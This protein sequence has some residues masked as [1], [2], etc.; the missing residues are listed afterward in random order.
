VLPLLTNGD[1]RAQIGENIDQRAA[2][3]PAKDVS[4]WRL[5]R[6]VRFKGVDNPTVRQLLHA[7]IDRWEWD[8]VNE[9]IQAQAQAQTQTLISFDLATAET[10][11]TGQRLPQSIR[12]VYDTSAQPATVFQLTRH[13]AVTVNGT[14]YATLQGRYGADTYFHL[15]LP[16]GT[17][18]G[19]EQ[20]R[21]FLRDSLEG[22]T[23]VVVTPTTCKP[24]AGGPALERSPGAGGSRNSW[25]GWARALLAG[26]G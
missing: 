14:R 17:P 24:P 10:V 26:T 7:L 20:I 6:R 11:I 16:L 4:E 22:S 8:V 23:T 1:V 21:G 9:Q 25:V 12:R 18:F 15:A 3:K 19:R 2:K 13:N 5:P